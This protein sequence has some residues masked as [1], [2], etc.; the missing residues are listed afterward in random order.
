MITNPEKQFITLFNQKTV[1]TLSL[2][3]MTPITFKSS[4]NL[5]NIDFISRTIFQI[6]DDY[7]FNMVRISPCRSFIA[8][9]NTKNSIK[10]F[11]LEEKQLTLHSTGELD[12]AEIKKTGFDIGDIY[13]I[14]DQKS[15]QINHGIVEIHFLDSNTLVVFTIDK[16]WHIF[17]L[18]RKKNKKNF[19]YRNSGYIPNMNSNC[20]KTKKSKKMKKRDYVKFYEEVNKLTITGCSSSKKLTRNKKQMIMLSAISVNDEKIQSYLYLFTSKWRPNKKKKRKEFKLIFEARLALNDPQI[21]ED[22]SSPPIVLKNIFYQDS[23]YC[24]TWEKSKILK[25]KIDLNENN[26]EDKMKAV[27]W[28]CSTGMNSAVNIV[29]S[30]KV[31]KVSEEDNDSFVLK[32]SISS[33]EIDNKIFYVFDCEGN[34]LKIDTQIQNAKSQNE[35]EETVFKYLT[36]SIQSKEATEEESE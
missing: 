6:E 26:S 11:E 3:P 27:N 31:V 17:K 19:K 32:G 29:M 23:C 35:L 12:T 36:E 33:E 28:I 20:P 8:I 24:L 18:I 5:V 22:D 34:I 14:E 7:D 13:G 2:D 16:I 15:D 30:D 9:H 4:L 10:I 25:L 21:K 1:T